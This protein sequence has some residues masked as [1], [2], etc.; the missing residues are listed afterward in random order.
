MSYV[1][2]CTRLAGAKF[3]MCTVVAGL[4]VPL[5]CFDLLLLP[6]CSRPGATSQGCAG[7]GCSSLVG[8]L[9]RV[10]AFAFILEIGFPSWT[11][12]CDEIYVYTHIYIYI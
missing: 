8:V 11:D 3:E 9:H 1:L 6:E 12:D 10:F 5:A 2:I 4:G 7:H